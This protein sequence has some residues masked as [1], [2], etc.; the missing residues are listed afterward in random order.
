MTDMTVADKIKDF[1][2]QQQTQKL[3]PAYLNGLQKDAGTE[4]LDPDLKAAVAAAALAA[5]TNAPAVAP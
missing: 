1:L 5:A 4:I 3:A 2:I